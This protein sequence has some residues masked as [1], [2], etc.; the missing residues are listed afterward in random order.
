MRSEIKDAVRPVG[1]CVDYDN[2]FD[3]CRETWTKV[4]EILRGAGANVFCITSRFPDCPVRDFPGVV[5][6]ASGQPKW[7]FAEENGIDV[8]IW[9]D[10]WPAM[11]GE[12]PDRKGVLPPQFYMRQEILARRAKHEAV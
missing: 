7:E 2:T 12:H 8:A 6:Y 11:I 10:D 1:I 9:I 3:T 4:I 5:H